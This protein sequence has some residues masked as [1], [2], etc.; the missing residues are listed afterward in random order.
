MNPARAF[1]PAMVT[2]DMTR[3]WVSSEKVN[4][5]WAISE[6]RSRHG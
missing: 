1:G 2:G 4:D 6:T 5:N 3:H